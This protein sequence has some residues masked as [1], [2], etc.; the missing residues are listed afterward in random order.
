MVRRTSLGARRIPELGVAH[1]GRGTRQES[2]GELASER[3]STPPN[4]SRPAPPLPRA[5]SSDLPSALTGVE[6]RLADLGARSAAAC[7]PDTRLSPRAAHALVRTDSP[8][9]TVG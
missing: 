5:R 4:Q 9:H 7:G 8:T 3:A 1:C 6:V 2:S